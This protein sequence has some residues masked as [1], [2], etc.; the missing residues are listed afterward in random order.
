MRDAVKSDAAWAPRPYGA[1]AAWARFHGRDGRGTHGQD[2]HATDSDHSI[3]DPW[4][5][6]GF[7]RAILLAA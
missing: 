3:D 5:D 2:A 7:V 1:G 6:G 4:R